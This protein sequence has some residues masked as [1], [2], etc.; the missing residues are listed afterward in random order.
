M[1]EMKSRLASLISENQRWMIT[2]MVA[3]L[4]ILVALLK[5]T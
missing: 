1:A 2:P 3:T 5:L 4:A